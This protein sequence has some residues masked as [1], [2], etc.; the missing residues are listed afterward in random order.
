MKYFDISEF[1]C[2][3]T[4]ENAM[5]PEFLERLDKLRENCG[6]AFRITSGY[7]S[8]LHPEEAKKVKPGFHAAGL[9]ADIAVVSGIER[10]AIINEAVRMHFPGIGV[11]KSFVHVDDRKLIAPELPE[12]IWSY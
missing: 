7:R 12:V 2:S 8:T 4:G 9:A 6:F 5:D 3:Y 1:D 10:R 11:A